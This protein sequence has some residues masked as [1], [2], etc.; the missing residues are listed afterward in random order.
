MITIKDIFKAFDSPVRIVIQGE[1]NQACTVKQPV[2]DEEKLSIAQ[3]E[4]Q[5]LEM[6]NQKGDL[7][8]ADLSTLLDLSRDT[9]ARRL[10]T[11][12]KDN[13]V[14]IIGSG[15]NITYSTDP[16]KLSCAR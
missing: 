15:S 5:I 16:E 2:R 4:A 6:L 13:R 1:G 12:V 3:Q 7:T 10:R 8:S 14:A 9:I 11:L